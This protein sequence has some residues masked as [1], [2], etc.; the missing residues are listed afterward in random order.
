M[1]IFLHIFELVDFTVCFIFSKIQIGESIIQMLS[2]PLSLS[3]LWSTYYLTVVA[4]I[5]MFSLGMQYYDACHVEW[6]NHALTKSAVAGISWIWLH[7]PMSYHLFRVGAGFETL[8]H[9]MHDDHHLDKDFMKLFSVSL[10]VVTFLLT[11]IRLTNTNFEGIRNPYDLAKFLSRLFFSGLQ[12]SVMSWHLE[13]PIDFLLVHAC[14]S[15][16]AFNVLDVVYDLLALGWDDSEYDDLEYVEDEEEYSDEQDKSETNSMQ[17]GNQPDQSSKVPRRNSTKAPRPSSKLGLI[18]NKFSNNSDSGRIKK[19]VQSNKSA[20]SGKSSHSSG[21]VTRMAEELRKVPR[22]WSNMHLTRAKSEA[23]LRMLQY[24]LTG[25]NSNEGDDRV[26]RN[27]SGGDLPNNV[28]GETIHEDNEEHELSES[29]HIDISNNNNNNSELPVIREVHTEDQ[30]DG[31]TST[32]GDARM[33]S[34]DTGDGVVQI[35]HHDDLNTSS[36]SIEPGAA[37]VNNVLH[38]KE[39]RIHPV[40]TRRTI[41]NAAGLSGKNNLFA[42]SGKNPKALSSKRLTLDSGDVEMSYDGFVFTVNNEKNKDVFKKKKHDSDISFRRN[43]SNKA[44]NSSS[45]APITTTTT[46]NSSNETSSHFSLVEFG[47]KSLSMRRVLPELGSLSGK[48]SQIAPTINSHNHSGIG[49]ES[50]NSKAV[51]NH[52]QQSGGNSNSNHKS[53]GNN[54]EELSDLAQAMEEEDAQQ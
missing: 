19:G 2:I 13:T 32:D 34:N 11:L 30:L 49:A 40:L 20:A 33:I 26:T 6:Y 27:H 44:S 52:H 46:A 16:C 45:K 48:S 7:V 37:T 17:T 24:D 50:S 43:T 8:F 21:K 39:P 42:M 53:K 25:D 41:D 18:S 4:V 36:K 31:H 28:V 54:I 35:V 15:V 22:Q 51:R 29:R 38:R 10:G 12:I 14:I 1:L 5:L 47:R 3:H 9:D 23:S